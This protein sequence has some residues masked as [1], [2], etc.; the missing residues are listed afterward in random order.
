MVTKHIQIAQE[1]HKPSAFSVAK[2]AGNRAL[3]TNN[4]NGGPRLS[5]SGVLDAA[6]QPRA[7]IE[8]GVVGGR[9]GGVGRSR[10]LALSMSTEGTGRPALVP[11]QP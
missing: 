2:D 3:S 5:G 8:R 7:G 1:D 10:A 4:H 6:G 9:L 11:C